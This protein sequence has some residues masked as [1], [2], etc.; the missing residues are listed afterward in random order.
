MD[1]KLWGGEG[2]EEGV[3]SRLNKFKYM[4][5]RIILEFM[6]YFPRLFM[7]INIIPF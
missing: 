5:V 2:R 1:V 6:E 7:F 3:S 4:I